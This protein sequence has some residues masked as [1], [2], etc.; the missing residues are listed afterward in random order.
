MNVEIESE[1]AQVPEKEYINGISVAVWR[2]YHAWHWGN[3]HTLGGQNTSWFQ[4][5]D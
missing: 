4:I 2:S 1:A 5:L 3:Y